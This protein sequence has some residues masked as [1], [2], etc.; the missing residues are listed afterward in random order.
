MKETKRATVV[1][2]MK[3]GVERIERALINAAKCPDMTDREV[4][5]IRNQLVASRRVTGR[6]EKK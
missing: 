2:N 6:L 4:V 5:D 3:A 1:A